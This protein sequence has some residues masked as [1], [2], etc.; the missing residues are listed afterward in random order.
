[1]S[2]AVDDEDIQ[3]F[4]VE[5]YDNLDQIEQDI[6]ALE[7]PSA[8]RDALTR[9]YRSLHTIKGNC[10]FLPFPK[11]E[12]IAHAG[13]SLLGQLRDQSVGITP[14]ITSILLQTADGLR[15]MLRAIEA[16][17]SETEID[18]ST[19]IKTLEAVQSGSPPQ[20]LDSWVQ[21]SKLTASEDTE[22]ATSTIR[23]NVGLLDQVMTLVEE[24]VLV[25]NEVVSFSDGLNNSSF[26]GVCQRLNLITSDLQE[27]IMRTRMQP[28]NTIFQK[29]PRVVRDLAIAHHKQ[30]QI[31]IE[32]AET[33]L[34]RRLIEHIKDPLTHLIRN[35]VDHGIELP[36]VRVAQGKL[37]QGQ[38]SIRAFHEQ[39][40]VNLEIRDD[41]KGI[42][43]DRLK[44]RSQQ[45]GILTSTQ[46]DALSDQEAFDLMFLPGFSTAEHVT[47]LSGRGV[48]MDVVR[49]NLERVN[50][51]IEVRSQINIGTTFRI[52]IPLTLAIVSALLISS[53]NERFAIAQTN[54]QELVRLEGQQ[55][56]Q[57]ET[58]YDIPVYRL[59]ETLLPL[60]YL[61]SVLQLTDKVT[62]SE[63]V[64]LVVIQAD[65]YQ[66]GVVV[67]AIDD[68]QEIVVKPLGK[69]LKELA[70]YAG[71][72]ILGDGQIA[73]ILDAVGLAKQSNVMAQFQKRLSAIAPT[74]AEEALD[75]QL[76]LLIEGPQRSRMGIPMLAAI[77]LETFPSSA[78]ERVGNQDLVRYRDRILPL[79]D[80]HQIFGNSVPE[81]DEL[82]V[83]VVALSAI[84]SVG[85]IV[86][87]IL[88]IVEDSL[89]FKGAATR[90]G[91]RFCTNIQDQVTEMLDIDAIVEI[92]NPHLLRQVG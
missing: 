74:I 88:D 54:I 92:V 32:G 1:M 35:C 23:V 91:I 27:G 26:T 82:S 51:T 10:G 90:P 14:Q 42:A 31:H 29:F 67:D 12:A 25:R 61:N 33:E 45:L 52:K 72:T 46:A 8:D 57:I 21:S 43:P 77:R 37:P 70:I 60:V 41:G 49:S 53:G 44:Q 89:S 63:I 87:R 22:V 73:L 24:L 56:A 76:I 7:D 75:Q 50:G 34:D 47:N 83:V 80:L 40:K 81:R 62:D 4:L 71:A 79:I 69:Q 18:Y 66:F 86:D 38:L 11:L 64:Y 84:S 68:V 19:L 55:I 36:E 58:L 65:D 15:Q 13:E 48:G 39:G 5:S 3:A 9:L 2:I 6:L 85:I 59:R 28:M 78:I 20:N 17:G 16:T 30:V